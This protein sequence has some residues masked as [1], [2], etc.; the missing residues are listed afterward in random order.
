MKR[1]IGNCRQKTI[2]PKLIIRKPRWAGIGPENDI[3][4]ASVPLI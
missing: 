3:S 1:V 2:F 4:P